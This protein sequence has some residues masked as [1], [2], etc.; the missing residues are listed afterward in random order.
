VKSKKPHIRKIDDALWFCHHPDEDID[1]DR[2]GTGT[3]NTP[4]SAYYDWVFNDRNGER[5]N[6]NEYHR[7]PQRAIGRMSMVIAIITTVSI[8]SLAVYVL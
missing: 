5:Y 4:F 8:G 3:G 6:I 7:N 1:F 2:T